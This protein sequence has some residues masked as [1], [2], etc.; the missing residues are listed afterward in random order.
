LLE[1]LLCYHVFGIYYHIRNLIRYILLCKLFYRCANLQFLNGKLKFCKAWMK[2][3]L[4]CDVY[5]RNMLQTCW[6]KNESISIRIGNVTQFFLL[7]F[8]LW[9]NMDRLHRGLATSWIA[10]R[11]WRTLLHADSS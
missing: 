6:F 4:V 3:K 2:H 7:F 10:E 1:V 11:L 5:Y 9:Q 8:L